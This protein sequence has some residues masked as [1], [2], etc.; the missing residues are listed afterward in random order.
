MAMLFIQDKYHAVVTCAPWGEGLQVVTH[1]LTCTDVTLL[2]VPSANVIQEKKINAAQ[3]M[4]IVENFCYIGANLI[5]QVYVNANFSI[6][7]KAN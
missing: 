7:L 6:V 3:D 1:H 2:N 4:C 5:A